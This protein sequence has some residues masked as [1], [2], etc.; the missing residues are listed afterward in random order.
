MQNLIN[1]ELEVDIPLPGENVGRVLNNE[2]NQELVLKIVNKFQ[3]SLNR[4]RVLKAARS[5]LNTF[6]PV[7][8]GIE[9]YYSENFGD[10]TGVTI[11]KADV[12]NKIN[13]SAWINTFDSVYTEVFKPV[14]ADL[15]GLLGNSTPTEFTN[16]AQYL[17]ENRLSRYLAPRGHAALQ[18]HYREQADLYGS[19]FNLVW[20]KYVRETSQAERRPFCNHYESGLSGNRVHYHVEEVKRWPGEWGHNWEGMIPG[21]DQDSIF[22]NGGGYNCLH[23]F[24]YEPASNVSKKDRR[25]AREFL[26]PGIV[27]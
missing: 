5:I 7:T 18:N 27:V 19:G 3:D 14:F 4:G 11:Q 24:R 17:I 2:N 16:R 6:E 12:R 9:R 8:D 26:G 13:K 25:A 21:T 10:P 1:R 22:Q 20:V 15:Q 23:S